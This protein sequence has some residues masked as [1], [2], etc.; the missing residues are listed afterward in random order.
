MVPQYA[1]EEL[2][3]VPDVVMYKK[4]P[5]K[6]RNEQT[7]TITGLYVCVLGAPEDGDNKAADTTTNLTKTCWA[8][9]TDEDVAAPETTVNPKQLKTSG[10]RREEQMVDD[11]IPSR[12]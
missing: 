5:D 2:L 9:A 12:V 4:Q 8:T 6:T 1:D 11:T 3:E 7:R 10:E